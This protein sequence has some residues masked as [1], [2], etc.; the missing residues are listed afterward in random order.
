MHTECVMSRYLSNNSPLYVTRERMWAWH[1][2]D[3]TTHGVGMGTPFIDRQKVQ[4]A[5]TGCKAGLT[6]QSHVHKRTNPSFVCGLNHMRVQS[7][8]PI[9]LPA[10]SHA[11]SRCSRI[12]RL[13][14]LGSW[15]G[16]KV[17]VMFVML[18][19]LGVA[20]SSASLV[21]PILGRTERQ[22]MSA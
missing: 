10:A 1:L 8:G 3:V 2:A 19:I 5:A 15:L 12:D 7:H 6:H 20:S 11:T 16:E 13:P 9:R 22:L 14:D 21:Y 4:I 18:K 17:S